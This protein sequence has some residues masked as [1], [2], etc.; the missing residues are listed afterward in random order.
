[1]RIL[2]LVKSAAFNPRTSSRLADQLLEENDD[3][4]GE[5]KKNEYQFFIC[6]IV[7]SVLEIKHQYAYTNRIREWNSLCKFFAGHVIGVALRQAAG[8]KLRVSEDL[9][10]SIRGSRRIRSSHNLDFLNN[11]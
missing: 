8:Y 11:R 9:R 5:R 7:C 3:R 1:M 2:R 4:D 6:N 10:Q